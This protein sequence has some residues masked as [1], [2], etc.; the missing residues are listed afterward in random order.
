[1]SQTNVTIGDQSFAYVVAPVLANN[2]ST[3]AG[4]NSMGIVRF[5]QTVDMTALTTTATSHTVSVLADT[6][7]GTGRTF[8]PQQVIINTGATAV[9]TTACTSLALTDNSDVEIIK[10][11]SAGLSA[12]ANTG[13]W[14]PTTNTT[15]SAPISTGAGCTAA[16][17]LKIA[18]VK[19]SATV[20][21]GSTVTVTGWGFVV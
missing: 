11:L 9:G 16:K 19:S 14:C 15:I 21:T 18:I 12:N 7:I 8:F 3:V 6:V 2:A 20:N 13:H 4:A 5:K 1:M 10:V 17:G